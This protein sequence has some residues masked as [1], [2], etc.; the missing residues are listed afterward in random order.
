M[1]L[2]AL[3]LGRGIKSTFGETISP[4][5]ESSILSELETPVPVANDGKAKTE[6]K[7][8]EK[9]ESPK[10]EEK[11]HPAHES[12]AKYL[13]AKEAGDSEAE[14]FHK[15][16]L[17]KHLGHEANDDK[18]EVEDL[19]EPSV[20]GDEEEKQEEKTASE[21]KDEEHA[22]D[23]EIHDKGDSVL[24]AA[25][26]SA[27]EFIK[28]SRPIIAALVAKPRS[29]RT[30]QEQVMIDSYNKSVKS[31]NAAGGRA[32]SALSRPK[33]PDNVSGLATDSTSTTAV[34]TGCDCF[35]GVPYRQGME[36]HKNTCLKGK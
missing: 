27:R 12:L 25:N 3:I 28:S 2:R 8:E 13:A 30:T 36:R 16:E 10:E 35:D 18:E 11:M 19:K 34:N 9:K 4:E 26:D 31:V 32:Y 24:K 6:E 20:A 23:T 14:S 7:K 21:Q 33:I 22:T 5:Q 17:M 29:K 1:S 15:G